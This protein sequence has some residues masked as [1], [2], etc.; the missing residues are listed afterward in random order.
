MTTFRLRRPSFSALTISSF[1]FKHP[2]FILS[3]IFFLT[4][5]ADLLQIGLLIFKVKLTNAIAFCL[6]VGL[7]FS[8]ALKIQKEF[9][10]L[11][12]LILG[13]MILSMLNSPNLISSFGFL[14]FFIFNYLFYFVISYNQF[15]LFPA[16]KIFKV[17]SVSF[18]CVG[19]YAFLQVLFSHLGIILPGVGQYIGNLARGSAFCYEPSFY[20]LYMTPFTIYSTS[21]F[22]LQDQATRKIRDILWPN[23]FLLASTSTGCLFTYL[24]F[25]FLLAI[26]NFLRIVKLPINKI[27]L[28]FF[29]FSISAFSLL[30]VTNKQL[31][32]AGLLKFFYGG[33]TS[34]FSVS[35]RWRGLVEYWDIFL[36]NPLFGVSFGGGPFYLSKKKTGYMTDLLDPETLSLY[37]PMNITT[38]ILASVGFLGGLLFVCFLYLLAVNFRSA[39]R[40]QCLTNEERITLISFALSI[41]VL[42]F[43]LQFSQS[44]M[45]CY[46]WIH[47]GLFCGYIDHLKTKSQVLAI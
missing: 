31:I 41:C 3:F 43:T 24:F 42:F 23:I 2:L 27:I 11:T 32:N 17:Y 34:H 37:S 29:I 38:E 45:R 15:N 36:E 35:D 5:S 30:W 47:I 12:L 8:R 44:I 4:S 14:F 28:K 10:F 40:I 39:L 33:G 1:F 7:F 16:E 26:F 13:T 21:K 6:L 25:L 22:I 20:A 18:Y 19:F 46:M 9:F